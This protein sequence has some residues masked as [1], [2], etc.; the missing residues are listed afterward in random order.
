MEIGTQT[1]PIFSAAFFLPQLDHP[2]NCVKVAAL[3]RLEALVSHFWPQIASDLPKLSVHLH[4][5]KYNALVGY[6]WPRTKNL[7][8]TVL[9]LCLLLRFASFIFVPNITPSAV[10]CTFTSTI[11][12]IR[13][14]L[15]YWRITCLILQHRLNT[16]IPLLVRVCTESLSARS[17]DKAL[18]VYKSE[19][20]LRLQSKEPLPPVDPRL[21]ALFNRKCEI[22]LRSGEC[23]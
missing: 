1:A 13:L 4:Y 11:S 19:Q 8:S 20:E 16:L 6:L 2:N 21:E 17:A 23:E 3:K 15:P 10:R 22:A 7:L 12:H 9:R 18:D 14:T 5:R